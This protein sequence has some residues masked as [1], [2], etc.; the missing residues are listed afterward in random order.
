MDSWRE[1]LSL[2][3]LIPMYACMYVCRVFSSMYCVAY[4]YLCT[5][6]KMFCMFLFCMFMYAWVS[7]L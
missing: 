4:G 7:R 5:D 2:S 3:Y 6:N 1:L